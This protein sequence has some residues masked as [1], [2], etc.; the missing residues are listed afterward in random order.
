MN[1]ALDVFSL[2]NF[3]LA[4]SAFAMLG[5]KLSAWLSGNYIETLEP[6][7]VTSRSLRAKTSRLSNP[8]LKTFLSHIKKVPEI[9]L[10]KL[11]LA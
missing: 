6:L 7:T 9:K 3:L 10:V 2:L 8:D 5:K 4:F 11:C 1:D